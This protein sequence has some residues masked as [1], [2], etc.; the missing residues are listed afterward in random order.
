MT[1]TVINTIRER[2]G[3]LKPEMEIY[4]GLWTVFEKCFMNTLETTVQAQQPGDTFVITGDIPAMWLRDST[5]QVLH[6]LRFADDENVATLIE[7][8]IARQ[9]KNVL[10][11]P[12]AN[13]YNREP[14]DFKPY[15][16]T[17]RAS[18]WVW[19]RKYEID[20]LCH[21][22]LLAWRFYEKT[23][24]TGFMT[25]M[26][27]ESLRT[28]VDVFR[29][30]QNHDESTYRFQRTNCPPSDTLVNDGKGAPVKVTGMTWSGFRPSDDAC[31]YGY[32]VPANLFAAQELGH[33]A[34]F[35]EIMGDEELKAEAEEVKAGIE[36]GIE[37]YAKVQHPE[38]GEIYAF[39]TDGYGNYNLMDDAN[40]PSLLALPYLGI[41]EKDDA[42]YLRTRQFV[43]SK[44]NPY[45]YEG[46]CAKG[47]G[48]PHTPKGYVWPIGLCV[49]GMTSTSTDE[50]AQIVD[51]LMHT[52]AGCECMHESFDPDAPEHFTREWFAWANSMFGELMYRTYESGKLAEV[53]NKALTVS[54]ANS[55][56]A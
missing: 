7:G 53:L 33:V 15:D 37:E 26:F 16:D 20:S 41:C 44:E 9:A 17:P 10:L 49:Q 18:D 5:A 52:H 12:Y 46:A 27:A 36:K 29:T 14:N 13:A 8:L 54:A 4:P 48:S 24:R 28:I 2:I 47:V 43:L 39:E 42:L 31:M 1:N 22:V 34:K 6:Y 56:R 32:L 45:Y 30:E 19:E 25:E 50:I 23:G 35:A 51:T 40:V 3:A 21:A 11:D 38:F 55:C